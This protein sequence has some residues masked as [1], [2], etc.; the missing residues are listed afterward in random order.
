MLK[1]KKKTVVRVMHF[2][3]LNATAFLTENK[4][5]RKEKKKKETKF[6]I[7]ASD[8]FYLQFVFPVSLSIIKKKRSYF[9]NQQK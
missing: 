7:S 5:K 3:A 6:E 4:N 8:L 9:P 1:K 2:Y